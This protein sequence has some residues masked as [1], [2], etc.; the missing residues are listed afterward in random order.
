M[1]VAPTGGLAELLREAGAEDP[2][3][4]YQCK[5]CSSSCP[6]AAAMDM[7]PS[8]MMRLAQ[9][10]LADRLIDDASIWRCLGCDACTQACPYDVSVRKLVEILRQKVVQEYWLAGKR[11]LFAANEVL[12]RGMGA[13]ELMSGRIKEH[14]NVSGEDNANRL[15][16]TDNL[17]ERPEGIDRRRGSET[18]YFVGCVSAMYPM[19]YAIPQN[20]AGV[21][22][23]SRIA[24]TT[25][26][27]LEWCCGFPLLMAGQLE[28][29]REFMAHN[30]AEVEALE[31]RRVVMTCPSCH[32]MW[33]NVYPKYLGRSLDFEVMTASELLHASAKQGRLQFSDSGRSGVVTYHDPCD[34]GRKGGRFEEPR[35][36]IRQVPGFTFVEMANNRTHALCCGGGGDL[37]TFESALTA[38]VAS[39][40]I[41]Q[42]AATGADHLVSACPQCVRTLTKAAKAAK[43]RI[44]V[45]DIVQFVNAAI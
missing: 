12:S 32:Y 35:D 28:Q 14:R 13:L 21:L 45:M 8:K 42:A 39:R 31:A 2:S 27:G 3:L 22:Q 37:E 24:F 41:A 40:R 5:R 29:A 43:Q 11:E 9:L 4:C 33:K 16:W 15:A 19:S 34:L 10:G 6:T 18:L 23:K 1:S 26:G 36:T 44:R 30:V 25:L 7:P 20:F 17:P 38:E